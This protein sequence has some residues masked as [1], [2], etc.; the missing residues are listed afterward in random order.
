MVTL[1][2]GGSLPNLNDYTKANRTNKYAGADMKKVEEARISYFIRQQLNNQKALEKVFIRFVW[3]EKDKRRDL[4][5]IC[6]AKK[7]ILDALVKNSI[8]KGDGW[9]CVMGFEDT[10]RVDK[11]R[12]RIEVY[13]E[14]VAHEGH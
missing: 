4:D 9:S 11:T 10:F 13:I 3:V 7:F 8:L 1:T 14:E 12:P 5:N 2:I 6:F